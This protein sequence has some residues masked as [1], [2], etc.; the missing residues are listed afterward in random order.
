MIDYKET[1]IK[2]MI[3]VLRNGQVMG[4]ILKAGKGF[5]YIPS[6]ATKGNTFDTIEECKQHIEDRLQILDLNLSLA[7]LPTPFHT[8]WQCS[9]VGTYVGMGV[10]KEEAVT[11]WF[12]CNRRFLSEIKGAIRVSIDGVL[13]RDPFKP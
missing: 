11:A 1:A 10:S 3:Q 5:K 9:S 12:L 4:S 13:W 7:E 8:G 6:N 2:G